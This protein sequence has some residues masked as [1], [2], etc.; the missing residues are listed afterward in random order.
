LSHSV[1]NTVCYCVNYGVPEKFAADV[2][3]RRIAESFHHEIV[4]SVTCE[5]WTYVVST[6]AF[7]DFTA[8][9]MTTQRDKNNQNKLILFKIINGR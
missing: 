4:S 9:I 8:M 7:T 5:L 2:A 1:V 6:H 3:D